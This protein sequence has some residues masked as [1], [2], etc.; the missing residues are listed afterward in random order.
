MKIN[1]KIKGK[2]KWINFWKFKSGFWTARI[3]ALG[4]L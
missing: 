4:V 2:W 1:N 3:L